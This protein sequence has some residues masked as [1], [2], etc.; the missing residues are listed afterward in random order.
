M[1]LGCVLVMEA[2]LLLQQLVVFGEFQLG[3]C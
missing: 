2:A 3:L 1:P